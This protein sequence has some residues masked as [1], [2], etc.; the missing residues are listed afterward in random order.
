VPQLP[1]TSID[2]AVKFDCPVW[3][4]A[5]ARTDDEHLIARERLNFRER[6]NLVRDDKP[7]GAS[8]VMPDHDE[9]STAI[10]SGL[11]KRRPTWLHQSSLKS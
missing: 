9:L 7:R 6:E 8:S 2:P 3:K 10:D 5:A 1:I 4:T 11:R